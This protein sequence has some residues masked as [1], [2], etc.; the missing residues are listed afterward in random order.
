[1]FLEKRQQKSPWKNRSNL[2]ILFVALLSAFVVVACNVQIGEP[3]KSS[4]YVSRVDEFLPLDGWKKGTVYLVD[5]TATD[6]KLKT[7]NEGTKVTFQAVSNDMVVDEEVYDVK[8]G[9]VLL[10]HAVGEDFVEP[11]PLLKFPL[12]IGDKYDWKGNLMFEGQSLKGSAQ[13]TTST[14]Y[15]NLKDKSQEAIRVEVNLRIA[16]NASRKLSFWFVKGMGA[17]K[18]EMGKNV[19]EPKV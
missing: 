6:F 7:S 19:R 15:V 17:L 16:D 11:I 4:P 8:D 1:M 14:D 18:T 10:C 3:E 9:K 13:V 2:S 12:S 5:G